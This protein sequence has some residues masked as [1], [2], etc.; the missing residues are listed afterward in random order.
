MI[1]FLIE[2]ADCIGP[3]NGTSPH[4]LRN[5]AFTKALGKSLG[6]PTI[7]F[8]PQTGLRI[9]IGEFANFLFASQRVL[10]TAFEKAG[11]QFKFPNIDSALANIVK[12]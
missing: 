7:L 8:V 1:E 10:P 4:P 12:S 6:R 2:D 3:F 5:T 9:A 11:F